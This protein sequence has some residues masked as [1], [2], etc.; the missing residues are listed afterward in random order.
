MIYLSH[1]SS[2]VVHQFS[3]DC[4]GAVADWL[5]A[6]RLAQGQPDPSYNDYRTRAA[7]LFPKRQ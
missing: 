2:S 6:H 1:S 7:Q 3:C 4:F 5:T